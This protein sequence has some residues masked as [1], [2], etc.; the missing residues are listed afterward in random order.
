[1]CCSWQIR[2]KR[3]WPVGS[4]SP[5]A[6]NRSVN[7]LPLS[8]RIWVILKGA[9]WR[10]WVRKPWAQAADFSGRISTYTQRVARSMAANS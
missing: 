6:Q 7:S 1:M 10:R 9:A 2:S 4:R 3:C 8:V 5:V